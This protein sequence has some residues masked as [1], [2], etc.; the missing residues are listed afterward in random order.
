MVLNSNG[1]LPQSVLLAGYGEYSAYD[2]GWFAFHAAAAA[3][4]RGSAPWG[5]SG[6]D[7]NGGLST[8]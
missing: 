6:H 5:G 1:Q 2:I 3:A 7:G 8:T 4:C